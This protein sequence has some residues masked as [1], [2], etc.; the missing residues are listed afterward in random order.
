MSGAGAERGAR[1]QTEILGAPPLLDHEFELFQKL[2]F[3]QAGIHLTQAKR[4][5]LIA[6]LSGRLRALG[7]TSFGAYYRLITKDG[8]LDERQRML[9]CI[10]TNET[11]FFREPK[12]FDFLERRV[13]PA[14]IEEAD[15]GRRPR[16]VR[17]W[18]AAC[19][20]GEE[21]FSVAM[22]LLHH[23][24]PTAGWSVE[25]LATDISTKVLERAKQAVYSVERASE[26][27]TPYLKAFMLKGTGSQEGKMKAGEELRSIVRFQWLNLN[28]ES[29]P[30]TG[31]FDLILC[32]NVLIYFNAESRK[33]AVERL[34]GHL[35]PDGYFLV[36]HAESLHGMTTEVRSVIPTVYTPARRG[37]SR[38]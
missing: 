27:P 29:Y 13:I 6:R 5:L 20:T 37:S 14:W 7:L 11:H 22:V 9:D 26:I 28:A 8:D 16:R 19:S 24:P 31:R 23:L 30:V 3:E 25:V 4:A 10:A 1:S 33:R 36:G 32:R 15:R 38:P 34:I 17:A 12:H 35:T 18:S 21:P 2:I